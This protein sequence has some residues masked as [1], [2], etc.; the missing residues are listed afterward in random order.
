[1]FQ[2]ITIAL[3]ILTYAL[4]HLVQ[5]CVNFIWSK[6]FKEPLLNSWWVRLLFFYL[7]SFPVIILEAVAAETRDR[8]PVMVSIIVLAYFT[9]GFFL[10]EGLRW[11]F[12]QYRK[13]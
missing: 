2:V 12:S 3:W 5:L 7:V 4:A 10:I 13:R 9:I 11:A 8:S 6:L 1:M